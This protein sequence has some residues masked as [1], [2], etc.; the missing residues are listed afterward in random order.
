MKK[1]SRA[2]PKEQG[3]AAAAAAAAAL[4]WTIFWQPCLPS[5]KRVLAAAEVLAEGVS[6][7]VLAAEASEWETVRLQ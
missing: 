6:P 3:T 1:S 5:A 2:L 4:R 7:S